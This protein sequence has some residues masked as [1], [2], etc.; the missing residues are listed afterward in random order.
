METQK[1]GFLKNV[2]KTDFFGWMRKSYSI[3]I[4]NSLR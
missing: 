3:Y 1:P 2:K 4:L